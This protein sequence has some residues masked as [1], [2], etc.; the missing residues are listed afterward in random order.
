M[1]HF[2]KSNRMRAEDVRYRRNGR[3]H[4]LAR[5]VSLFGPESGR[6]CNFERVL[7]SLKRGRRIFGEVSRS[8]MSTE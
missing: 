6:R 7:I 1:F 3:K 2:A 4:L 8:G 5:W